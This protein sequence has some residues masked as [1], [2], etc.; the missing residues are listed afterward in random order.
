MRRRS[1]SSPPGATVTSTAELPCSA[2]PTVAARHV[3]PFA[4][5]SSFVPLRLTPSLTL[6]R[7]TP[8]ASAAAR[9]AVS[10]M[11]LLGS[12]S[13]ALL[14]RLALPER[15]LQRV[16]QRALDDQHLDFPCNVLSR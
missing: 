15:P 14:Q 6:V 3:R 1:R 2:T 4:T 7:I 9:S 11:P 13:A 12:V 8:S 10:C 5:P 16:V